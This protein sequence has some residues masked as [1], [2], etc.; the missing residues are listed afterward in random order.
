MADSTTLE[1]R[2][3]RKDGGTVAVGNGCMG[4]ENEERKGD[5]DGCTRELP[6]ELWKQHRAE[7]CDTIHGYSYSMIAHSVRQRGDK[8]K[9]NTLLEIIGERSQRSRLSFAFQN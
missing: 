7:Q 9:Y 6:S 5:T 4:N 1:A 8:I 2:S 3:V